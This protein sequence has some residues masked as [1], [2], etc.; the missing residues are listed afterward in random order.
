MDAEQIAPTL[1]EFI[2]MELAR[3]IMGDEL[4]ELYGSPVGR[5]Y[6]FYIYRMMKEG[7]DEW[8][9]NINTPVK[10][11][12]NDIIAL[13]I[14]SAIDTLSERYGDIGDRW[15]WGRIHK[16][17][18]EHPMGGIRLLNF[19]IRLNSK[20]YGV[21]GSYHSV[22]PFAYNEAFRSVLGASERHIFNTA[23]WDKSLTV[24]PTGTSGIP[25][26]PFY[27][28]QTDTYIKNGFYT[29]PFTEKAVKAA[30]KFKMV[31]KTGD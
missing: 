8:I 21:G 23:D 5:Q 24:I 26:S 22:E 14:R 10:E 25:G 17:T 11:T 4:K 9:D 7:P 29:D 16:V 30:T 6:D 28:S 2:R 27:L 31:F 13:S 3:N 18:F 15:E 1:F 19:L 12:M 20:T